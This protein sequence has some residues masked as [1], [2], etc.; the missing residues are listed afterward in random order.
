MVTSFPV[1][2]TGLYDTPLRRIAIIPGDPVSFSFC[3]E[4]L[5]SQE[6]QISAFVGDT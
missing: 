5:F 6:Q 2:L 1:D 3:K 4:L